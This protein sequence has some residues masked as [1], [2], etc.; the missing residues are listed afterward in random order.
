MKVF[1]DHAE[2]FVFDHVGNRG[3]P[4]DLIY[5]ERLNKMDTLIL[6]FGISG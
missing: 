4:S 1:V 5:G 2:E 6:T 3:P